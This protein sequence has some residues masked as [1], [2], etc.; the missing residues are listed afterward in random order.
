MSSSTYPYRFKISLL[1]FCEDLKVF[2]DTK[3]HVVEYLEVVSE[4]LTGFHD[5]TLIDFFVKIIHDKK[6]DGK[7]VKKDFEDGLYFQVAVTILSSIPL[8]RNDLISEQDLLNLSDEDKDIL[9][10]YIKS[11]FSIAD[12]YTSGSK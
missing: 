12:N 1:T 3:N 11:F 5:V 10:E 4:L 8:V 9:V 7:T 6:E 2:F